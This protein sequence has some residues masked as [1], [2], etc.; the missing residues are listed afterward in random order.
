LSKERAERE[1]R[2]RD[3]R[4][5]EYHAMLLLDLSSRF[6]ENEKNT[7]LHYCTLKFEEVKGG[8]GG[9]CLDLQTCP[10]RALL[11]YVEREWSGA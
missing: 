1:R 8:Y 4:R 10:G 11:L 5:D 7:P 2:E 3:E 9:G 6:T